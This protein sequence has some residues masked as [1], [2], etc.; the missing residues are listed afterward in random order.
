MQCNQQY[1]RQHPITAL[2]FGCCCLEI[3]IDLLL[4]WLWL[5][6]VPR[7]LSRISSCK[8]RSELRIR[9]L[10]LLKAE[11]LVHSHLYAQQTVSCNK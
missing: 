6:G 4:Y 2:A 8:D 5:R 11:S 9:H 3:R 1:N 10:K 7:A